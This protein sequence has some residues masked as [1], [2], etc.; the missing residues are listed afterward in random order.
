MFYDSAGRA[1]ETRS[2][3]DINN[4]LVTFTIYNDAA[5]TT[6]TSVPFRVPHG[7][8]WLDPNTATID[9][10]S[11]KPTGTTSL[12][13]PLGR[14]MATQDPALGSAAEPGITC[15]GQNGTWTS[16]AYYAYG[17]ASG[18]SQNYGY[19][20]TVDGNQQMS[21]AFTD[22]LGRTR[23]V[24]SY[25]VAGN[26]GANITRKTETQFNALGLPTAVIVKDLT[27]QSGEDTAAV[28]TTATYDDMGRLTQL[29]DPDRG[30]I[31]DTYDAGGRALTVTSGSHTVGSSYDLLG[32]VLCVQDAAPTT[33]GSGA[34]SSG[35]HPLEQYTYGVSKLGTPGSTDFP[36]G[37]MTQ[38]IST[39]Y[40]PDGTSSQSTYQYQHD[41]RGQLTAETMQLSVP[42]S[43]NVS[44][45]L[46]TYKETQA[47]NDDGQATTTQT[48][49][50]GQ[51]GFTFSQAYDSTTGTLTGLSNNATGVANLASVSFEGH[52]L[53]SAIN[54]QTTTGT[55][56]ASEQFGYDGNLRATGA[57][58]TWQSGSG[59]TG[60]VYSENRSYDP[61]GNV[62]SKSSTYAAVP[63][64]TGS[65]GSETQNF[66]Y[67]E[68]NQLT[69]AGNSGTQPA[70]TTGGS[71]GTATAQS[72]GSSALSVLVYAD[73]KTRWR[74]NGKPPRPYMERL[75]Y[76]SLLIFPSTGP[77]L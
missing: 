54:Y 74:N 14:V 71:C 61:I 19:T 20:E 32:R 49:V 9:G 76:F 16:C 39:T 7:T 69:W 62:S 1:V 60:T 31:T 72:G 53:T 2:P 42:S 33:D 57:T 67:N 43:W 51:P 77:L 75:I 15:S 45:A 36:T 56:L 37:R 13:D 29:N 21:V 17:Q 50:N 27:P 12:V 18:D 66:C 48:T 4:D 40:Y 8:G 63:G 41:A 64:Q 23:Y 44:T 6:F 55:A 46:P 25:S 11:V 10:G 38:D 52:G 30:T 22:V 70:T 26:S 73:F 58:A 24:Q 59:S 28:T 47:Y 35:S 34:C 65:G 5:D 3:L 68:L